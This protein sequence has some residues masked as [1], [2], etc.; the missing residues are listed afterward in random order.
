MSAEVVSL[1]A[2]RRE[3]AERAA[4]AQADTSPLRRHYQ[5]EMSD[6][7]LAIWAISTAIKK[8]KRPCRQHRKRATSR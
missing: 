1:D 4:A 8:G 6:L 5:R 2:A 3:R 7:R